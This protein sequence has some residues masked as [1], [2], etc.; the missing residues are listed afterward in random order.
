VVDWPVCNGRRTCLHHSGPRGPE[1]M[2]RGLNMN[3][4]SRVIRAAFAAATI[5]ATVVA[6]GAPLK[7]Y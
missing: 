6:L 7:W 5:G 1:E 3:F 4:K 2:V